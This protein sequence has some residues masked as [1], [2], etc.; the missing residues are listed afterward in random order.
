MSTSVKANRPVGRAAKSD[1]RRDEAGDDS[2]QIAQSAAPR[3][4]IERKRLSIEIID[5]LFPE[6]RLKEFQT[7]PN[8]PVTNR[9]LRFLAQLNI[10]SRHFDKK[11]TT[12]F[13]NH[14]RACR[15]IGMASISQF[16]C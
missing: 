13:L 16:P 3:Q 14:V 10:E 1:E 7:L 6:L 2:K 11:L 8:E 9:R 15:E 5:L 12:K 4:G